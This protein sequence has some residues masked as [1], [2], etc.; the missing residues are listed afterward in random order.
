MPAID[1]YIGL[2]KKLGYQFAEPANLTLAL[3]HRSANKNHNERLEF[4]GDAI[5][6]MIIAK[7]LFQRF[8]AQ[9]EGKLT[10]MRASLVKGVTLAAMAKEFALGDLLQLG[11][12]ELKSGGFRR[13]SIL[14][15]AFEA[16]IGAI[17]L[18]AGFEQCERIVLYWF[19]ERITELDP[20]AV[21]KDD[22]TRLQEYLQAKKLPLPQYDVVDITGQSH[23]QMFFVACQVSGLEQSTVGK[24]NSR[25]KAEQKAARLAY[26]KLTH[27]N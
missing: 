22:K 4:L 6:G 20:L 26:E 2:Y 27:V 15:D 10:R 18:E 8:P 16:I 21:I 17:Y 1:P 9:P 25:R 3:T 13:E 12:G 5:L 7:A 23:D 19:A 24:G 14:A 11:P